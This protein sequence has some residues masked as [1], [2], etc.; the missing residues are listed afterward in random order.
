MV[1]VLEWA[2]LSGHYR[3]SRKAMKREQMRWKCGATR[4][5]CN[6]SLTEKERWGLR[7]LENVH[8]TWTSGANLSGQRAPHAILKGSNRK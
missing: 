1:W 4:L 6:I 5:S 8:D 7:L 3:R 2:S